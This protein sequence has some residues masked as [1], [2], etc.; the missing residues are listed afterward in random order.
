MITLH[1]SRFDY[2][3]STPDEFR[4]MVETHEKREK[5]TNQRVARILAMLYNTNRSPKARPKG[6]ADFMPRILKRQTPEEM[7]RAAEQWT[8]LLA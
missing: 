1:L 6:E 5:V 2:W 8:H 7:L 4:R 3:G